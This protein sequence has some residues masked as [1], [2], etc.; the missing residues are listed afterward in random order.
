MKKNVLAYLTRIHDGELQL[1][2]GSSRENPEAGLLVPY[3]QVESDEREEEALY[4]EIEE[5]T[6]LI[7]LRFVGKLD[8]IQQVRSP[9][10]LSEEWHFFQVE[11]ARPT[12][13]QWEHVV[14]C[15]S[16]EDGATYD[17]FWVSLSQAQVK[18]RDSHRQALHR[19]GRRRGQA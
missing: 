19:L 11:S 12:P 15:L 9:R 8:C 4:R 13:Y 1:L 5:K 16:E 6:G 18:L 10:R 2:V 17:Y 14:D 3:G 7:Y